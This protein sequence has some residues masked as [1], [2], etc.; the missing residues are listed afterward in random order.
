[1][2]LLFYGFVVITSVGRVGLVFVM[3]RD[4]RDETREDVRYP[5]IKGN[6]CRINQGWVN[7]SRGLVR[8]NREAEGGP[9]VDGFLRG[10]MSECGS[11]PEY[12]AW[13]RVGQGETWKG[14]SKGRKE[15]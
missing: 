5:G 15:S 13:F 8:A 7:E 2:F 9:S 6:R 1:M 14:G 10:G 12:V 11:N 3:L 4:V